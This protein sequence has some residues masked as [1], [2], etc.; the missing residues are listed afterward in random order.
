MNLEPATFALFPKILPIGP[1]LATN[2]STKQVG[3]F[4]SEDSSCLTWLD[5]Q[6]FRSVIYVA[7]GSITLLGKSQFE[8]LALGLESTKKRFLWVV[9]PGKNGNT[10]HEYPSGYMDRIGARGKV[11]SWAPQQ[12]VLNHPSVACFMSHCVGTLQWKGS[13]MGFLSC[14]GHTLLSSVGLDKNDAGIVTREEIKIKVEELLSNNLIKENAL[15]VQETVMN[16]LQ[17]GNSSNKN[18]NNFIDWIKKGNHHV[19]DDET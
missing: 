17:V 13:A 2:R 19:G 1:L 10:D 3:H 11:V 16:S 6:P 4:W 15:S 12:E 18:L 8:E 5:Q 9:R 7:F 14:V